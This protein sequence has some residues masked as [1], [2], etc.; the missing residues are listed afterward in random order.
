MKT[1]LT[2]QYKAALKMLEGTIEK[3]PDTLWNDGS[4]TNIFWQIVYHTLHY[5]NLYVAKDEES[6]IPWPKHV[7]NWHRFDAVNKDPKRGTIGFNYSKADLLDYTSLTRE[8]LEESID[9]MNFY[10][11]TDFEW[12]N[13]NT[14]ELHLYNLRHL[15]HHTGQLIE[16]LQQHRIQGLVWI[17]TG[18]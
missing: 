13:M 18:N 10:N 5:T 17:N 4:Y 11:Q 8:R 7:D 16:R 12:V 2:S 14:L 15:Q 1:E 6:F 9:E 3:C